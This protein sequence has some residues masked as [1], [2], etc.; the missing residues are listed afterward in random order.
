RVGTVDKA[1]GAEAPVVLVSYT[2]S[3]AADIPRNFEF[4]YD[5]NRLNVAVSRAQALAVVVASPAL[6]SVECKTIEQVKLANML[7]RFAECA[8]E[9]KLPDN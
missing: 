6:L 8:E 2:S 3:S 7:C 4:L 9:V 1:Q 5:K